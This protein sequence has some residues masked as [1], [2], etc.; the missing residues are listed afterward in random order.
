MSHT[1]MFNKPLPV[2]V[3]CARAEDVSPFGDTIVYLDPPYVGRTGYG[4][5]APTLASI[6]R[7]VAT[8][9][10]AGAT[11]AL[12]SPWK[13]AGHS[14]TVELTHLRKG[15]SRRSLTKNAD[16]YLHVFTPELK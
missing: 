7:V 8:W 4:G 5:A 9:C 15:Q 13:D 11:V 16:E 3:R 1:G 10:A 12:S 14:R 6:D 2:E